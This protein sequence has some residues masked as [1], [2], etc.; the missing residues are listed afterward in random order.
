[1]KIKVEKRECHGNLMV[2]ITE[3][4]VRIW[5]CNDFGENIF[6]FKALGKVSKS[7]QDVIVIGELKE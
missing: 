7:K 3:N 1:M 5:V 6:R 4:E 2:S